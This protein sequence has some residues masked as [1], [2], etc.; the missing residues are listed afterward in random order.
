MKRM[1]KKYDA[2][3]NLLCVGT[4]SGGIEITEEE[5]NILLTEIKAANQPD[6]SDTDEISDEEAL[7][8]ILGVSE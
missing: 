1:Y 4:G 3:G 7:N 6:E 2:H 8:I 5:Y